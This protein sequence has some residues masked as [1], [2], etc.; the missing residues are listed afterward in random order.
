MVR[1]S[2]AHFDADVEGVGDA[3]REGDGDREA[4]MTATARP[5][6]TALG[7]LDGEA[8]GDGDGMTCAVGEACGPT[9]GTSTAPRAGCSVRATVNCLPGSWHAVRLLSSPECLRPLMSCHQLEWLRV[10]VGCESA[11]ATNV[12]LTATATARTAATATVAALRLPRPRS[13]LRARPPSGNHLYLELSSGDVSVLGNAWRNAS[14][15]APAM[16]GGRGHGNRLTAPPAQRAGPVICA[17]LALHN[18][19]AD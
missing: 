11:S 8:D 3:D 12:T 2:K 19:R 7:E 6:A 10:G 1:P 14:V 13:V 15:P 4:K 9:V 16:Q 17:G 18:V 5:T